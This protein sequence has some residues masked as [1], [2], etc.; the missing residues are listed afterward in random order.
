MTIFIE[1]QAVGCWLL[2]KSETSNPLRSGAEHRL[3]R[4]RR[5]CV[6]PL[7]GAQSCAQFYF[8]AKFGQH[9]LQGAD[10]GNGVQVIVEAEVGDAEELSFHLALAVGNHCAEVISQFLDD[11]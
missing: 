2:A 6:G 5:L 7:S 4:G 9:V 10:D 3:Y 8:S 11:V 1:N